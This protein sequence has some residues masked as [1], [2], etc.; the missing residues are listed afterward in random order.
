MT[1][2]QA[3]LLRCPFC[4]IEGPHDQFEH[5]SF[6]GKSVRFVVKCTGCGAEAE[7]KWWNTRAPSREAELREALED[8]ASILRAMGCKAAADVALDI[9][10]T[11]PAQQAESGPRVTVADDG[12][13]R[14]VEPSPQQEK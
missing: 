10:A 13:F 7:R 3:H 14:V 6:G 11:T 1:D 8:A 9:A 4:G 2:A 12:S 5:F